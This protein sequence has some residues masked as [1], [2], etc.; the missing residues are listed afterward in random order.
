MSIRELANQFK[1]AETF[2]PAIVYPTHVVQTV[3]GDGTLLQDGGFVWEQLVNE[4][5][6]LVLTGDFQSLDGWTP[7]SSTTM[8][9]VG[10]QLEVVSTDT[11]RVV[12]Y[13][14][15]TTVGSPYTVGRD[16]IATNGG[17]L[18]IRDANDAKLIN[19]VTGTGTYIFVA[20]TTTTAIRC[21]TPNSTGTYYFDNISI[22]E[23]PASG[24]TAPSDMAP[25]DGVWD[26]NLV[27]E[28]AVAETGYINGGSADAALTPNVDAATTPWLP[29]P[30]G[31]TSIT[32]T[33]GDRSTTQYKS[34]LGVITQAG[35]NV[36]PTDTVEF[37]TYFSSPTDST[38]I[39][40]ITITADPGYI[41]TDGTV[42]WRQ[43][44]PASP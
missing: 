12:A 21:H 4:G 37:R 23:V 3:Y 16:I 15:E 13:E 6:E 36:P 25:L 10:G 43:V 20:T 31:A 19:N 35:L 38:P 33:G 17:F 41:V 42:Q 39:S 32:V 30:A 11:Y 8:A 7:A 29:F 26:E 18:Q 28:D 1:L 22:K 14:I 44:R 2:G 24:A 27:P 9:L 40:D 5:A 34:A